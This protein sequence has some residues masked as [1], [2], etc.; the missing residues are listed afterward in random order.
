MLHWSVV[1]S[2]VQPLHILIRHHVGPEVQANGADTFNPSVMYSILSMTPAADN[3]P[4]P[5]STVPIPCL[6]LSP[7]RNAEDRV[8]A[9]LD[10]ADGRERAQTLSYM[11]AEAVNSGRGVRAQ[12]KPSGHPHRNR[13]PERR[14]IG[15]GDADGRSRM[16][17]V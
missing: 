3:Q 1:A 12:G 9:M 4:E 6:T 8:S 14:T 11:A 7:D 13:R 2:R 17:L 16:I 10:R 15:L 5:D